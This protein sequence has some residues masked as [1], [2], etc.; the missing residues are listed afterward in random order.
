MD[1]RVCRFLAL[2][3]VKWVIHV[4]I[5]TRRLFSAHFSP[6]IRTLDF[7]EI[8]GRSIYKIENVTRYGFF[9][10]FVSRTKHLLRIVQA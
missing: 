9:N 3:Y 5:L 2:F 7:L 4:Y 1:F 6:V 10:I 8:F